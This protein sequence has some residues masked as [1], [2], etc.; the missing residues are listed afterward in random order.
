MQMHAFAFGAKCGG[1]AARGFASSVVKGAA[2]ISPS[3]R[4]SDASARVPM[5]LAEVARKLRRAW[6]R[7]FMVRSGGWESS[8]NRLPDA[9]RR[10]KRL[11][12]QHERPALL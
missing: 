11:T 4:R 7:G 2:A 8:R 9:S 3:S 12:E 1:R 6:R 10:G 5:P